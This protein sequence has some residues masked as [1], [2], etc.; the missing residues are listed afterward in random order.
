[1]KT[2]VLVQLVLLYLAIKNTGHSYFIRHLSGNPEC[3]FSWTK[4]EH[5]PG[6]HQGLRAINLQ[7]RAGGKIGNRSHVVGKSTC[8][9][10]N[11][12]HFVQP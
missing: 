12:C 5:K 2:T 4:A 3:R 6:S 10:K 7:G 8:M 9:G 11:S 1:M